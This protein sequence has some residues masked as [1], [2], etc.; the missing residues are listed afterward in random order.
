MNARIECDNHVHDLGSLRL[1]SSENAKMWIGILAGIGSIITTIVGLTLF[2]QNAEHRATMGEAAT[3]AVA[4]RATNLEAASAR[5]EGT[6]EEIRK[7]TTEG[8]AS[9]REMKVQLET[10]LDTIK[11]IDRKLDRRLPEGG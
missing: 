4:A 2:A 6:M 1:G 5:I 10:A 7:A 9:R 8:E 11:G 3:A